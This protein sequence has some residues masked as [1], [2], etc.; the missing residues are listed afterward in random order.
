MAN[1]V[2]VSVLLYGET[3]QFSMAADGRTLLDGARDAGLDLP[4]SCEAGSCATCR[5]QL[6]SGQV[7]MLNNLV[8]DAGELGAGYV[9]V[10]QSVPRSDDIALDFDC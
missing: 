10:C 7:E 8:L 2:R 1:C 6:T 5:A 4:A 3:R 9:L